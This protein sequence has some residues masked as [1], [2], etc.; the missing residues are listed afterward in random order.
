MYAAPHRMLNVCKDI[1][2]SR[3]AADPSAKGF[4]EE[5]PDGIVDSEP[6]GSIAR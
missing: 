6:C 3:E 4:G 2:S 5:F 1:L